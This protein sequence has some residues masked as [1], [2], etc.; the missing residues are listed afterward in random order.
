[1]LE[2]FNW[3]MKAEICVDISLI[4]SIRKYSEF[5]V[6]LQSFCN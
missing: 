3:L 4:K 2:L 5:T 1:M 6:V